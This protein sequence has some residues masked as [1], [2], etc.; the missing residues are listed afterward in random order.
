MTLP[1]V[2]GDYR[3][4]GIK[5]VM[6][7]NKKVQTRTTIGRLPRYSQKDEKDGYWIVLGN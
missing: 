2:L 6:R 3:H 5:S 1:H 7:H 4:G